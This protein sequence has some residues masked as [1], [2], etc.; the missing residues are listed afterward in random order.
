MGAERV[1]VLGDPAV[2]YDGTT[3]LPYGVI[4][5]WSVAGPNC[6]DPV[7]GVS[8]VSSPGIHYGLGDRVP[9]ILASVICQ[10]AIYT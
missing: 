9:A 6:I 1:G 4:P 3:T 5:P 8:Y 2:W 10:K 7:C